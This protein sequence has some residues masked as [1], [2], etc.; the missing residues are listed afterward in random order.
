MKAEWFLVLMGLVL[1]AVLAEAALRLFP[2]AAIEAHRRGPAREYLFFEHDAS[3]GWRG[4]PH[5]QGTFSGWEFTS[6]VQLNGAGFRDRE[7]PEQKAPGVFRIVV[8][9]DSI[10]W[11]HGVNQAERYSDLLLALL[12]RKGLPVE[13][14]NLA[15]SG[16]GTD[17]AYLLFRSEEHRYC[18]DL[19]LFGFYENDLRENLSAVQGPYPKP[20]F[21]VGAGDELVLENVPVPRVSGRGQDRASARVTMESGLRAYLRHNLRLYAAL[22]FVKESVRRWSAGDQKPAAIPPEA[23]EIT[24][25]ILRQFAELVERAGSGF[26][27]IVL[28]DI[29]YTPLTA[30]AVA[31]SGITRSLNLTPVFLKAASEREPL[32]FALDG[33]HWTHRAHALAA[34]AIA[35]FVTQSRL[36]PAQPRTCGT[37]Q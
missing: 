15:V 9:G 3:L 18:P 37:K 23:V 32:F 10:T 5:A 24:A 19:V 12:Q 22:A 16:Y 35:E 25:A 27:V 1:S 8:M 7:W 26:A 11:G 17:Q 13:V 14:L 20:Y 31:R 36:L 33:A 28:P 2:V 29:G 30:R 4:R 21:R 6:T 34:Q